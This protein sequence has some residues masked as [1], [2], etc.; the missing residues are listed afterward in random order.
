VISLLNLKQVASISIIVLMMFSSLKDFLIILDFQLNR[1]AIAEEFCENLEV[2]ENC[3]GT[4]HLVKEIKK[5][6][7][8]ENKS[9]FAVNENV[10]N[11]VLFFE[12]I[13]DQNIFTLVSKNLNFSFLLKDFDSYP[14]DVFHPPKTSF[15]C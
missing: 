3:Q 7:P 13:K 2:D 5:D 4:C 15:L 12:L 14:S 6:S 11:E 9:P 10:K 8:E 1:I